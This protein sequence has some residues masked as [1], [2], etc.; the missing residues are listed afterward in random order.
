MPVYRIREEASRTGEAVWVAET[1]G[2]AHHLASLYDPVREA[3]KFAEGLGVSSGALVVLFGGGAPAV[4]AIATRP[5]L[6]RLLYHEPFPELRTDVGLP[7]RVECHATP[8]LLF[9]ALR[10]VGL[11]RVARFQV[12]LYPSYRAP[13]GAFGDWLVK[14]AR[15]S[16]EA[17][18]SEIQTLANIGLLVVENLLGNLRH[19]SRFQP[20]RALVSSRAPSPVVCVAGSGPSLEVSAPQIARARSRILLIAVASAAPALADRGIHPDVVVVLDPRPEESVHVEVL[21]EPTRRRT[22]WVV[23]SCVHPRL[24][25]MLPPDRTHLFSG[26]HP[27]EGWLWERL[28]HPGA[29]TGGGSVILPAFDL[30]RQLCAREIILAGADFSVGDGLRAHAR[31]TGRQKKALSASTRFATFES[32]SFWDAS[33][34]APR[35]VKDGERSYRTGENLLEY[36][37]QL[38]AEIARYD[39]R[40]THLTA[41]LTLAGATPAANLDAIP[42]PKDAGPSIPLEGLRAGALA[43]EKIVRDVV[44]ELQALLSSRIEESPLF[45]MAVESAVYDEI[46]RTRGSA[47]ESLRAAGE[48]LSV[49]FKQILGSGREGP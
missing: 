26:D 17:R 31:G 22:A 24:L 18:A 49:E 27:L 28:G 25:A 16:L 33:A 4:R 8:E 36:R 32:D 38:E 34:R 11:E 2:H 21:D 41:A 48:R 19:F 5:G 14:T 6:F 10:R 42:P 37:R 12:A 9:A 39:G 47:G 35:L 15:A 3:E 29:L 44:G 20:L 43:A 45:R 1:G 40:V 46:R 30:A 23:W 13:L 7:D